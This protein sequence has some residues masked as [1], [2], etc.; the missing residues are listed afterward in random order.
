MVL[1]DEPCITSSPQEHVPCG[2]LGIAAKSRRWAFYT[3]RMVENQLGD[4]G[5]LQFLAVSQ[6]L[7]RKRGAS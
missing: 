2:L 4:S 3:R 7:V 5:P 1:K 6:F